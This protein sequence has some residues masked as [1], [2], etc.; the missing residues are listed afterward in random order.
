MTPSHPPMHQG[1]E[2]DVPGET[3]PSYRMSLEAAKRTLDAVFDLHQHDRDDTAFASSEFPDIPGYR[4]Y[5]ILGSGASG[6]VMLAITERTE[7]IVAIKLLNRPIG[8]S[9][10][11]QRAWREIDALA[12]L[13]LPAIPRLLDHGLYAGRP[14]IVTDH[15]EGR[16]LAE[17]CEETNPSRRAR[18]ELLMTIADA[19]QSMHGQGVIHRDIKPS[20]ILID[21]QGQPHL[22]DLGVARLTSGDPVATITCEG[23]PVGSPAF[24]APE[25]ARGDRA[26]LSTRSD[27]YSLGATAYWLLTGQLPFDMSETLHEAIHRVA[28]HQP[29]QPRDFDPTF[30]APLNAILHQAV[31][32]DPARRY[33]AA[34]G[35]GED[36][37]RYLRGEPVQAA[38]RTPWQTAMALLTRHPLLTT[39]AASILLAL[40]IVGSMMTVDSW[41]MRH[42]VFRLEVTE[43]QLAAIVWPLNGPPLASW[44]TTP[45]AKLP[46]A[47]LEDRPPRFGGGRCVLIGLSLNGEPASVTQLCVFHEDDFEHP[48]WTSADSLTV[49]DSLR[50]AVKNKPAEDRF[51]VEDCIVADVFP[52]LPGDEIIATFFHSPFSPMAIRVYDFSGTILYEVWH[53]GYLLAMHWIAEQH[54]LVLVGENS[55][56]HWSD[57]GGPSEASKCPHVILALSP[58]QG[59]IGKTLAWPGF[60]GDVDPKWYYAIFPA[61]L[62]SSLLIG[63]ATFV[64]SALGNAASTCRVEIPARNA[65]GAALYF[66][67]DADGTVIDIGTGLRWSQSSQLP[68]PSE[69]RLGEL[70]GRSR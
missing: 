41:L 23:Q 26:L 3:P 4:V 35:F 36:L 31:S 63:N 29:R 62:S 59:V 34:A 49:P 55:D 46:F 69:I 39:T 11:T 67:V 70:P 43:D 27:V 65:G 8:S 24:M 60:D 12:Q 42:T 22:I 51:R 40:T 10:E 48:L 45:P 21:A 47:L 30:P 19:V 17:W 1:P 33:A 56:G 28:Y 15:I 37:G 44:R 54:T 68:D 53:D 66:I 57:R 61:E 58:Q 5:S 20:N 9:L 18:V 50:Y 16:T 14:F 32:R 52:E 13:N 7:Q 6:L 2:S 38:G 25:Q 64:D